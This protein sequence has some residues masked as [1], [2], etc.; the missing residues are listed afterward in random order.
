MPENL[1]LPVQHTVTQTQGVTLQK[2]VIVR[3]DNQTPGVVELTLAPL[4]ADG[5]WMPS[6]MPVVLRRE[7][8]LFESEPAQR[9][10][11]SAIQNLMFSAVCNGPAAQALG[12]EGL[13]V[14]DAAKVIIAAQVQEGD[15]QNGD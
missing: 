7:D 8:R 1:Y 2:L 9:F 4:S 14:W 5:Q 3:A 6:A 13:S 12:V 15:A 11:G 10:A